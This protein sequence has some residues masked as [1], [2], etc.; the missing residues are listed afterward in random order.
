MNEPENPAFLAAWGKLDADERRAV[1]VS[2]LTADAWVE[3]EC[4][5]CGFGVQVPKAS[6]TFDARHH[7]HV[8]GEHLRCPREHGG[9]TYWL[10]RVIS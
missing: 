3:C 7:A 4:E 5:K 2:V 6:T 10:L 1:V 8:D 9:N